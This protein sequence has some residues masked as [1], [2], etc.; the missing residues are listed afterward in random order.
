MQLT[1]RGVESML[2]SQAN[3]KGKNQNVQ[4]VF[5]QSVFLPKN[6][7]TSTKLVYFKAD[8]LFAM[9]IRSIPFIFRSIF[10]S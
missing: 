2:K 1:S 10:F 5:F 9:I 4:I 8:S 7:S 3:N 6:V